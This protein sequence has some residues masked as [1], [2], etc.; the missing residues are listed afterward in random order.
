[1]KYNEDIFKIEFNN[2]EPS[3]GCVLISEPFLQNAY[4]QRSLVYLID[5]S[6][7]GSMGFVLNKQLDIDLSDLISEIH[8][9]TKIPVFLGGPVGVET[10]FYIHTFPF[11]PESYKIT[12]KLYLNGDFE[13]LKDYINSGGEIEGRIKF[14]FG[15]SGWEKE[16]LKDEINENSWLVGAV[17]ENDVLK[18]E[19]TDAW[20][21]ALDTLGGKY[22]QW[23]KFPKDPSLN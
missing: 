21:Q 2:V 15:Y 18:S 8:T 23:A 9:K 1:M 4:F 7:I 5:H 19:E 22:K 17:P 10:L 3:K 6:E 12:D 16:Q 13:L 11:I 20:E 14:F